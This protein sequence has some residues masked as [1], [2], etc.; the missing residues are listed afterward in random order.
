[1]KI[2]GVSSVKGRRGQVIEFS[3]EEKVPLA[4]KESIN[5]LSVV[6]K[7]IC[8]AETITVDNLEYSPIG[9]KESKYTTNSYKAS[10]TV[11]C[12]TQNTEKNRLYP[13]KQY[14]YKIEFVDVTDELGLPDLKIDKFEMI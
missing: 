1:M 13:V 4:V 7:K 12:R 11:E 14:K 9:T 3:P 10:G 5:A 6:G 8:W 2:K